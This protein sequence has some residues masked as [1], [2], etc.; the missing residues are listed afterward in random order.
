M[1]TYMTTLGVAAAL[2][3]AQNM[4]AQAINK[5]WSAVAGFAGG[6]LFAN[7]AQHHRSYHRPAVYHQPVQHVVYQQP[8]QHV[9]YHQP[10]R[11]VHVRHQPAPQGYYEWRT[12]RVW[13]PGTWIYEPCGYNSHRKVWQAGYYTTV[14]NKVWVS[15]SSSSCGW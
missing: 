15:V 10:V 13:V 12:E 2:F 6:V 11:T 4:P 1:K 5:E 9:V 3:A 8:V 14:R 7:A